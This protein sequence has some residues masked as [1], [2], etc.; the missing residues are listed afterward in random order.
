RADVFALGAILCEILT[1]RPP[2]A[3]GSA[4]DVYRRAA[5]GD[6]A[7]ARARLDA[8]G[9]D[10]ALPELA[11][12]CLAADRAGRPADAG[13]V[14]RDVTAY[15][16]SAQERLRRAEVERAA[17]EARAG[18]ARA[19]AKAERRARRLTLALAA[20]LLLGAGAAA[21]QAVAA[22]RAKKVA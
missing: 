21:W 6:L 12:R 18:E 11:G 15:L 14:A 10:A 1:G 13:V 7:D 16:A 9:A 5:A 4:D 20:A 2:Y 22:T 3:G 17:A 8:C 19:K